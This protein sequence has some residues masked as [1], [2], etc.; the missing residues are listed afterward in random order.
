MV[1]VFNFFQR[2]TAAIGDEPLEMRKVEMGNGIGCIT[3]LSEDARKS[4]ATLAHFP[5]FR[6]SSD[7][8]DFLAILVCQPCIPHTFISL[9]SIFPFVVT[10]PGL[11]YGR[12]SSSFD[13]ARHWLNASI[14][15][16][17][18]SSESETDRRVSDVATRASIRLKFHVS[19]DRICSFDCCSRSAIEIDREEFFLRDI[20]DMSCREIWL[21]C[22]FEIVYNGKNFM[23]S[24]K[25][26]FSELTKPAE[27]NANVENFMKLETEFRK[28]HKLYKVIC[29]EQF[30]KS[31]NFNV[32]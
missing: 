24:V 31:F 8:H 29:A 28:I 21:G 17:T 5:P 26:K 18:R 25:W 19:P 27:R 20:V 22:S 14:Q 4:C 2:P 12:H 3:R 30:K 7:S 11:S 13:P 15:V 23:C 9:P 6:R 32:I 10:S 1:T 16:V